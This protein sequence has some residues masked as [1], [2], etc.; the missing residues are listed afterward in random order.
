MAAEPNRDI[1]ASAAAAAKF[2]LNV[3]AIAPF[4]A[5]KL[6]RGDSAQNGTVPP[7]PTTENSKCFLAGGR[8]C[9]A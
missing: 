3:V 4:S 6:S 9:S 1:A 2:Q 8:G 7:E 5:R